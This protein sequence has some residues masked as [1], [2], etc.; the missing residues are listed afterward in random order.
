MNKRVD[1]T[2]TVLFWLLGKDFVTE[3]VIMNI[4]RDFPT[5]KRMKVHGQ[6]DCFTIEAR[7][8]KRWIVIWVHEYPNRFLVYKL[9]SF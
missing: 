8:G 3:E 9:H 7:R 6:K 4:V 5:S 1:F 2:Y